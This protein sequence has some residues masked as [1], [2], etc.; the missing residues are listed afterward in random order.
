MIYFG[1]ISDIH[2]LP[3][4][5]FLI[6][7]SMLT[8]CYALFFKQVACYIHTYIRTYVRTYV[9]TYIQAHTHAHVENLY[10]MLH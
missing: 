3:V 10:Y 2:L 6:N 4:I 8:T 5:S 9:R 1:C 7:R